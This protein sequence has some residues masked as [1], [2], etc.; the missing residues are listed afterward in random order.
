MQSTNLKNKLKE[1]VSRDIQFKKRLLEKRAF[2]HAQTIFPI[3]ELT[4]E[5]PDYGIGIIPKLTAINN[6]NEEAIYIIDNCNDGIMK[7]SIMQ[8]LLTPDNAHKVLGCLARGKYYTMSIEEV[9]VFMGTSTSI[10]EILF[11]LDE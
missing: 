11:N 5:P 9:R 4:L 10:E 3:D 7:L 1:Q 6:T 8:R 2:A